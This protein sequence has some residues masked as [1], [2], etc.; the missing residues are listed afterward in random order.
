MSK[1]RGT[2]YYEYDNN[3]ITRKSDCSDKD[4]ST[5]KVFKKIFRQSYNYGIW[6]PLLK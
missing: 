2:V 1:R 4:T 6:S 3:N 5:K